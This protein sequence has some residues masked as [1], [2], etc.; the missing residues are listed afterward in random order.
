[1]IKVPLHEAVAAFCWP[2]DRMAWRVLTTLKFR[3]LRGCSGIGPGVSGRQPVKRHLCGV[4]SSVKYSL[5]VAA[6]FCLGGGSCSFRLSQNRLNFLLGSLLD[7]LM[8]SHY[9]IIK[10]GINTPLRTKKA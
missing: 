7:S 1:M 2:V 8:G 3:C 9:G 6:G 5:N 10:K 4:H